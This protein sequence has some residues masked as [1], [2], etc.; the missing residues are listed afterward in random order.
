MTRVTWFGELQSK[1]SDRD[2]C[3]LFM[4]ESAWPTWGIPL[5]LTCRSECLS[6]PFDRLRK[7]DGFSQ[8]RSCF[9]FFQVL[10]GDAESRLCVVALWFLCLVC[11]SGWH[12]VVVGHTQATSHLIKSR[13]VGQGTSHRSGRVSSALNGK[14]RGFFAPPFRLS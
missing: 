6:E 11:G 2:P 8:R 1:M 7:P 5:L 9:G 4:M 12:A 10:P 14:E 3:S 13:F